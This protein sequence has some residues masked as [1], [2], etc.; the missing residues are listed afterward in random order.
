MWN[1]LERKL[2]GNAMGIFIDVI[3]YAN[4]ASE[5]PWKNGV[6]STIANS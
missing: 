5:I 4:R 2:P 1:P 3:Q 6:E